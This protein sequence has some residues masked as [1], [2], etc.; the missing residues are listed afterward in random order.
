MV[1]RIRDACSEIGNHTYPYPLVPRFADRGLRTRV[2]WP[3]LI[4]YTAGDVIN[5][6]RVMHGA[7]DYEALF[8]SR[9]V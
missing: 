6:V 9:D 3:Y 8:S 4:F 1:E 7:R 5:V 2:I